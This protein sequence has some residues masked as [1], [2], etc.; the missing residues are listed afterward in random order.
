[1]RLA[2]AETPWT[3]T[4][5]RQPLTEQ[6]RPSTHPLHQLLQLHRQALLLPVLLLLHPQQPP[7][8]EPLPDSPSRHRRVWLTRKRRCYSAPMTNFNEHFS[9][10]F[11]LI[12]LLSFISVFNCYYKF[13]INILYIYFIICFN[14]SVLFISEIVLAFSVLIL[15][16]RF[17]PIAFH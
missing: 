4:T 7:L 11:F 16:S 13:S 12:S 6:R 15:Y 14:V 2:E 9:L 17:T 10:T 1:M 5:H 3:V 8:P